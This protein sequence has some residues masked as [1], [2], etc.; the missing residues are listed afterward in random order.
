LCSLYAQRQ[1]SIVKR[2]NAMTRVLKPFQV[3]RVYYAAALTQSG[4]SLVARL[5][6]LHMQPLWPAVIL[7]I[8]FD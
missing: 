8:D 3:Q 5:A 4:N 7:G 1:R 2:P 6:V